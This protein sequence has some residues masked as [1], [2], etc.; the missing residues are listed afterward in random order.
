M[1]RNRVISVWLALATHVAEEAIHLLLINCNEFVY[2][3]QQ[4]FAENSY[5]QG[6]RY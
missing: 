1:R 3:I 4:V 2:L 5:S 6:V